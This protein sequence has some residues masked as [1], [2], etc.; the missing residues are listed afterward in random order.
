MVY[1]GREEEGAEP[2]NLAAAPNRAEKTTRIAPWGVLGTGFGEG[3][4]DRSGPL[5]SLNPKQPPS[6]MRYIL[7]LAVAVLAL[8][9]AA[10]AQSDA[11]SVTVTVPTVELLDV[12]PASLSMTLVAPATIG[13]SLEVSD[14]SSSYSVFVNTTGN[15]ITGA[16]TVD[17]FST[18]ALYSTLG[19]PA[20]ATS[21]GQKRL[22]TTAVDLVTGVSSVQGSGYSLA[23]TAKAPATLAAGS[24]SGTI[25]YT[26]Q[27]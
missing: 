21:A 27:N 19:A 7:I 6:T 13:D 12:T 17:N 5:G 14:A 24:Y 22:S 9:P 11:Q 3:F 23:Y 8:A 15:R 20:G 2:E 4:H 26:I 18:V 10:Y 16:I 25:T 1:S